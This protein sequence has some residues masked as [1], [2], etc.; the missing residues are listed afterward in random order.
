MQH[1]QITKLSQPSLSQPCPV[2]TKHNC[3]KPQLTENITVTC[4]ICILLVK[5][6]GNANHSQICQRVV[7]HYKQI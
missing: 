1:P 3:S 5:F 7:E 2:V 4:E 6:H